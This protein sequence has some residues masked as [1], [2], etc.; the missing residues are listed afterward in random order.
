MEACAAP[1]WL[2]Y[3]IPQSKSV[4]ESD[5]T[6]MRSMLACGAMACDHSTSVDVS[7]AQLALVEAICPQGAMILTVTIGRPKLVEK[8]FKSA[9]MFGLPKA[10]IIAMLCPVPVALLA[11]NPYASRIWLGVYAVLS[12]GV[13]VIFLIRRSPLSR[14]SFPPNAEAA[15]KLT[16]EPIVKTLLRIFMILPKLGYAIDRIKSKYDTVSDVFYS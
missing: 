6:T 11:L 9:W 12:C 13:V 5:G 14:A 15:N 8:I 2:T 4:V 16:I 3:L 1:V 7:S 10:S